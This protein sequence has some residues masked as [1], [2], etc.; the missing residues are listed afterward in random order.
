MLR[1]VEAR[2]LKRDEAH[3]VLLTLLLLLSYCTFTLAENHMTMNMNLKVVEEWF[4]INNKSN[5]GR[6]V[7]FYRNLNKIEPLA[8]QH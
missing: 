3:P 6:K 7:R 4:N 8:L 2:I 1:P 5:Q